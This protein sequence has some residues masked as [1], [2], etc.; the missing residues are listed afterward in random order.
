MSQGIN[1][2]GHKIHRGGVAILIK[3]KLHI[4]KSSQHIQYGGHNWA[5]VTITLHDGYHLNLVTSYTKHGHGLEALKT[6]TKVREF[7]DTFTLPYVW[8]GGTSIVHQ[9]SLPRRLVRMDLESNALPP[10][11]YTAHAVMGD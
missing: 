4:H 8:G 1:W 2:E 9:G 5:A 11:G 7:L 10:L 6:F 3:D